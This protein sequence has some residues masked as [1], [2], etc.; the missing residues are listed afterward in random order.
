MASFFKALNETGS[1]PAIIALVP[2]YSEAYVHQPVQE[3][4]PDVLTELKD[5]DAV[6]LNY[7]ELLKK[8]QTME[9]KV[10]PM[11]NQILGYGI[12]SVLAG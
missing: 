3:H 1:K 5:D 12:D 10:E 11:N 7:S 9:I 8:C 6:E 4:F 2:A